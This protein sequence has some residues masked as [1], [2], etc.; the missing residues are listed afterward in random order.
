MAPIFILQSIQNTGVCW[1]W[2]PCFF[3]TAQQFQAKYFF[4]FSKCFY[5]MISF[6][7]Y[8]FIWSKLC[9]KYSIWPTRFLKPKKLRQLVQFRILSE[10]RMLDQWPSSEFSALDQPGFSLYY[11]SKVTAYIYPSYFIILYKSLPT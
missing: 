6:Y 9:N 7:P 11:Y 2:N 1:P 8:S 3:H 4:I 5:S 10:T